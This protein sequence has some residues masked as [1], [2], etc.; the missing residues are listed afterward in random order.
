MSIIFKCIQLKL[1]FIDLS[2]VDLGVGGG[3]LYAL[4]LLTPFAPLLP[5]APLLVVAALGLSGFIP[6]FFSSLSMSR[7]GLSTIFSITDCSATVLPLKC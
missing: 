2:L 4:S 6:I 5:R 3:L 1:H 7:P